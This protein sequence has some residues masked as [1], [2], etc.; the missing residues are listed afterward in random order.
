M[1]T[2]RALIALILSPLPVLAQ[3]AP[4]I[5]DADGNGTWSL[6]ELQVAYPDLTQDSFTAMDVNADG[7]IDA[8][9]LAKAIGDGM[10]PATPAN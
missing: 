5:A 8:E 7:G 9:E 10:L 3:D 4:A 6:E 1:K 2:R